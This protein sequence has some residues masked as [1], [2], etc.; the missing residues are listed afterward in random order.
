[1]HL[2]AGTSLPLLGSPSSFAAHADIGHGALLTLF[3]AYLVW[4]EAELASRDDT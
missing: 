1:M 4:K 3:A 2:V